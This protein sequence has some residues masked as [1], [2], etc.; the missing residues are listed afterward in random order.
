MT[1][2][3]LVQATSQ[4]T[5][6]A[7]FVSTTMSIVLASSSPFKRRL[8][9]PT[10]MQ[11]IEPTPMPQEEIAHMSIIQQESITQQPVVQIPMTQEE[12]IVPEPIPM[13]QEEIVP[14]P[15][16]IQLKEEFDERIRTLEKRFNKTSN[17]RNNNNNDDKNTNNDGYSNDNKVHRAGRGSVE[18]QQEA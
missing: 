15:N 2:A 17:N 11:K 14:E 4:A 1:V 13:T 9:I 10:F 16:I 3:I 18:P 7:P 5:S 8:I 6:S 12:E